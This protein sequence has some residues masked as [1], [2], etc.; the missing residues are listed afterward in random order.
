[1]ILHNKIYKTETTGTVSTPNETDVRTSNF[2]TINSEV[3]S[4]ALLNRMLERRRTIDVASG[5]PSILHEVSK[6]GVVELPV[7]E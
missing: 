6:V 7:D 1:M 2:L 4:E 5:V 3:T